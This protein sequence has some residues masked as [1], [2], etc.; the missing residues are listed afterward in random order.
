MKSQTQRAGL[1]GAVFAAFTML[2]LSIANSL[3]VYQ[4]A[5]N[6]MEQWHM[7]Y[8]PT[9]AGTITGM[10]EAAIITYLSILVVGWIYEMLGSKKK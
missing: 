2:L 1:T 10:V 7:F 8:S 6:M 3:G 5:V 9:V 4:G